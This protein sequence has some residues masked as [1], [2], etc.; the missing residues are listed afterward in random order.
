MKDSAAVA[1]LDS[2]VLTVGFSS[3]GEK[4]IVVTLALGGRPIGFD[5]GMELMVEI[6]QYGELP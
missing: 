3:F 4:G 1:K 5:N 6:S 2:E